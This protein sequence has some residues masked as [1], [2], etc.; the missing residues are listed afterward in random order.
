MARFVKFKP[1]G[2]RKIAA[3]MGYTGSM[4]NFNSYLDKNPNKR[5]EMNMYES[6]AQ[7]MAKGGYVRMQEG[8]TPT[9]GADGYANPATSKE[10]QQQRDMVAKTNYQQLPQTEVPVGGNVG[11]DKSIADVT[12]DRLQDPRL[13][14]GGVTVPIGVG[15]NENQFIDEDTGQVSGDI[16][17]DAT[18]ADTTL[19]DTPTQTDANTVTAETSSD[20]VNAA[21]D[22]V[23]AAQTDPNDP[24]SKVIAAEQTESSVSSLDA[25]QGK[26]IKLENPVQREIQDGELIDGAANAEKAAMFAEQVQAAEATPSEKAT[27]QGQLSEL[28]TQFEG[29][30]T[31][32]WASGAMRKV[33]EQMSARGLS[34]SSIAGQALIQAAMESALPIAMADAR[35]FTAFERQNLSNRQQRALMAA[36]QRAKFIG[37][38]FDQAFKARVIN[39][40]KI[41]DIANR[42]FTA[43]QQIALENSRA[44]NSMNLANL[45]NRQ[46][47][48]MAEASAL[49][50]LDMAN[51]NNR[52]KAAVQN[53]QNFLQLEMANLS[54]LQQT[55]LFKA[56]QRTQAL[57]TDQAAINAANQFNATSQNQTD[58]FF[59]NLAQTA[60]QFNATQA[61]A[62]AQFNAGQTNTVERFNAEIDNQRDQFNATNQLAIAQSNAVWRREIATA[63]TAAINR[64]NELNASAVLD[65]SKTAYDN[66][67]SYFSDSMEWAWTSADNQLDRLNAL[68]IANISADAKSEAAQ[69]QS[70]SAA[71]TA[72]GKLIGTLGAAYITSVF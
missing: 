59:A 66:L 48:V 63:D 35:T 65:I 18:T 67:W 43:E 22:T 55:E 15:T 16:K 38:E 61:N 40:S 68:A 42:N 14:Q 52:Q 50:Q 10:E 34:S 3:K 64:A 2:M 28:M 58:Q 44:A 27:V 6:V 7:R 60:S 41:S 45:N 47:L 49:S 51:L 19:A 53:A 56:Q 62:Q 5:Q 46:A 69:L 54:N 57:F 12:A 72:L 1:E 39:A 36:Q 20:K 26:H 30:N 31:P 13:P 11:T 25:A 33:A 70:S 37:Q 32:A 71:G 23:N 21:L 9:L 24:K 4:N 8:G 29:G 17:V